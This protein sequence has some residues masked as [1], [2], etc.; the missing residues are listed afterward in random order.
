MTGIAG[1]DGA[2]L[3][4]ALVGYGESLTAHLIVVASGLM[5]RWAV[6]AG[7]DAWRPATSL[8][9]SCARCCPSRTARTPQEVRAL[10]L[11]CGTTP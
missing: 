7:G 10:L 2:E 6:R 4:A 3:D 11:T 5:S 9:T 8:A 1:L